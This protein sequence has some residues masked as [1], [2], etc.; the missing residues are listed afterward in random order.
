MTVRTLGRATLI[1]IIFATLTA[2]AGAQ[3]QA[4][5]GGMMQHQ[6]M[7]HQQAMPT[8]QMAQMQSMMQRTSQMMQRSQQLMQHAQAMPMSGAGA[9]AMQQ[10]TQPLST[11]A[12]QAN[13]FAGQMNGLMQ[14]P[15]TM[16]DAAMHRDMVQMQKHLG[17]MTGSLEQMIQAMEKMQTHA[18]PPARP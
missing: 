15:K 4:A 1:A 6:G 18:P 13:G 3:G 16:T 10:M 5:A 2:G 9:A 12:A 17:N 8:Q 7:M 11:M 14:D